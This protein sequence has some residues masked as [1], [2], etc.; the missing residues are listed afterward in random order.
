[1]GRGGIEKVLQYLGDYL[2]AMF[3]H[4]D[5]T[6]EDCDVTCC[7]FCVG[8]SKFILSLDL[9]WSFQRIHPCP[10]QAIKMCT[11]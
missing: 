2:P 10:Y 6:M 8:F 7:H 4:P 3:S 9:K 5:K 11:R 1:M